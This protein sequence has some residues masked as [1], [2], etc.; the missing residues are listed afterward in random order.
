MRRGLKELGEFTL[1]YA[2]LKIFGFMPRS[3]ARPAAQAFV[4]FGFQLARRQRLAGMR[5]LDLAFPEKNEFEPR[6]NLRGC[7]R[8]LGRLLVEFSHFPELNKRNIR[9][10]VAVEGFENYEDAVRRGRGVIYLTG[11]LGAWELGSFSQ[12][13]FGYPLK[14]VIR[15]IANTRVEH[16]ISSYR[17]L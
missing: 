13:I 8:N 10:F 14:F 16:L 7:F 4:W 17:M 11:H 6:E 5:N 9:E 1:A 15:P 12:S 3:I 2:L